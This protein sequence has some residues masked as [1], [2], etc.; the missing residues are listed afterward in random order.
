MS[1]TRGPFERFDDAYAYIA[2]FTNY[3]RMTD[4]KYTRGTLDLDRV[5]VVLHELGDPQE[6][7]S[8]VHVAGTK[9][10]G[11]VCAMVASVLRHAGHRVGLFSKPHLIR[12]NERIS[13]NS[14][15]IPDARFVEVMNEMHPHLERQRLSKNPLTFFDLITVLALG[16]FA[17]EGVDVVVLEVGLGGRLDSTNVVRPSVSVITSI[18][19]DHTHLLGDTLEE[20]AY[21]KA[22]IIKPGVPVVSGV[23]EGEPARV[24]E[25]AARERGAPLFVYGRDFTPQEPNNADGFAVET[26]RH[27]Y[28]DLKI[29]L[30]GTH[31]R[32]NAAVAVAAL[33][34]LRNAT[35]IE[36]SDQDIRQGLENVKLRG[37]IEVLQRAPTVVL[38][39]AHNPSSLR[40]LR[41]TLPEHFPDTSWV[42]LIGMSR[43]KEIET[44]LREILPIAS[45]AVFTM[46]GCVRGA[47]P[48]KLEECAMALFPELR[49]E[50]TPDIDEALKR[51]LALAGRAG[52]LCVTG[53]FYLAGEIAARWE[54]IAPEMMAR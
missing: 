40:A 49:C 51:A 16:Y 4:F 34:A 21:E 25:R 26:W 3:E 2:R 48:Q 35:G 10:K 24:I 18:D 33:E 13:I 44:N 11:S 29:P 30:L 36:P 15:E 45:H 41:A 46:T 27:S 23:A 14:Q 1:G 20:I 47:V 43:D 53:S 52:G 12:L 28:P 9:G 54:R 8:I 39:A 7:Y 19:Y 22:G 42:M 31:Q 37:R 6:Q 5:R 32:R 17:Q 50:V 38:D